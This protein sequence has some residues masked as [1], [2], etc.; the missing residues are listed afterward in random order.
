MAPGLELQ[1]ETRNKPSV[2]IIGAPYAFRLSSCVGPLGT[3]VPL[4]LAAIIG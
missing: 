1:P 3:E 4:V 2:L